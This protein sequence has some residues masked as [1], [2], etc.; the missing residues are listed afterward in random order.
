VARTTG[1]S[2]YHQSRFWITYDKVA[3]AVDQRVGW[4]RLPRLAGILVLIGVRDLLRKENLHDTSAHP[5]VN[6]PPVPPLTPGL[7]R[8]RSADGSHNDLGQPAM[9][10]SGARF[11]RN[12]GTPSTAPEPLPG[13][14]EP[15]PRQVS[16]VL[17][18]RS[19]LNAATGANA[20]VASWLQF[21]IRDWFSHGEGTRERSFELPLDDDD[22]WAE[23][24]MV[25]PKTNLDPTCPPGST[26]PPTYVNVHSHWWDASSIYG[27][28][29]FDQEL[30]RTESGGK[31]HLTPDGLIPFPTGPESPAMIPGFWLGL[32]ML[33]TLFAREHNAIC[34]MLA[35]TYPDMAGDDDEL[36]RVARLV[37]AALIAKI[38]TVEWTPTVISHPTTR[39]AMRINWWGIAGE[40]VHRL[41]GRLGKSEVIS[42]I[43][44]SPTNHYGIP[45]ALTEEFVAVYRMH[46]LVPDDYSLRSLV[47]DHPL[48]DATLRSL[49]GPAALEV[50]SRIGMADLFYSFGTLHPG[51]VTL[52]NFPR[53]LQEFERPDG[54]VMDLAAVDVLRA[55]EQGVPRYNEFRRLLHL[56]PARTFADLTDNP[57]WAR[58][59]EEV[60]GDIERVDLMA[61]MYAERRPK[62]FAF[63]DTAFRIFVLM[64]SRRLNSDRFFTN[65]YR[66]EVY[67][68]AGLKWIEDNSMRTVLQRHFPELK[69]AMGG[70]TN[71]FAAWSRA[72]RPATAA[73]P[74]V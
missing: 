55:R 73:P 51:L 44:G 3:T 29:S 47:D 27:D 26:L 34:D 45:Y 54:Q 24:P 56:K 10:R 7:E 72:G 11:G 74:S 40:R 41:V 62:G 22:D 36:F 23:R 70:V 50:Q 49:S 6:A 60:Y 43:P 14:L 4:H 48:E 71:G 9:G 16:R 66:A 53:F 19:Q 64:A 28:N 46:P 58:E 31:V 8:G 25:V 38:H 1:R 52:H 30:I 42:G 67:T 15:N 20:L 65:D 32:V 18:T 63:S 39:W 13:L 37:N 33:Q 17:M 59:L 21:M 12:V 35:S 69:P 5:S 2:T 57:V 68:K 61:G